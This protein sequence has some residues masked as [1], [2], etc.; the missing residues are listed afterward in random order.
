MKVFLAAVIF[1]GLCVLGLG[2]NIF[3]RKNGHF[4]D[5]EIETNPNM[6]K[7]GIKCAKQEE[8]ELWGKKGKG[9]HPAGCDGNY[10]DACE[11]CA[12]FNRHA[13]PDRASN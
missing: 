7:L 12:L 4:P 9:S 8:I 1:V 13:R 10:S 5:T 3:F 2:F 11:S 6:K